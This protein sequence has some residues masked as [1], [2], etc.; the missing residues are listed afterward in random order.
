M[1]GV[2]TSVLVDKANFDGLL[3]YGPQIVEFYTY[4]PAAI[5]VISEFC[6]DNGIVPALHTPTPHPTGI[7]RY[8][9]TGPDPDEAEAAA[10]A[11]EATVRC[12]AELAAQHV[13]VHFPTPYPPHPAD[14]FDRFAGPFLD[15]AAVL[16]R[17]HGV[18]VLLENLTPNT[19]CSSA[20]QYAKVLDGWPDLGL[21]LDVGHAF[22][23]AGPDEVLA[24]ADLVGDRIKSVHLYDT[25]PDVPGH[26]PYPA[27][28]H[29]RAPAVPHEV[30]A[31]VIRTCRPAAVV[32]EH[33]S[34]DRVAPDHATLDWL[35]QVA[36]PHLEENRR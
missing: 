24:F 10:V 16:A 35:R 12:A 9:P 5:P 32:L 21:C 4:P 30:I 28:G 36:A 15:F 6:A 7:T 29:G 2:S 3:E 22:L 31:H 26:H 27:P 19:H 20:E 33:E 8:C 34:S 11:M 13:V 17:E 1:L 23:R 14:A 25:D 18:T